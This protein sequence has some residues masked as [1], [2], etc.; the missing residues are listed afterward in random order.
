MTQVYFRAWTLNATQAT[1]HV[2]FLG[3]LRGQQESWE[4][5]LRHWLQRLPC[6]E[7]K[8][9]VGNFLSVYR[10]RPSRDADGHSDDDGADEP[11]VLAPEQLTKALC[12]LLPA[13]SHR[14]G[15]AH[16]DDRAH[17]V[18]EAVQQADALWSTQMLPDVLRRPPPHAY[19]DLSADAVRKAARVHPTK[20]HAM[21]PPEEQVAAVQTTPDKTEEAVQ[22]WLAELTGKDNCNAEQA[23][24]CTKLGVRILQELHDSQLEPGNLCRRCSMGPAY[25]EE[26]GEASDR[27]AWS[28]AAL[29]RT[30]SRHPRAHGARPLRTDRRRMAHR[31]PSA[32]APGRALRGQPRLPARERDLCARKLDSGTP[33]VRDACMRS[34]G[35]SEP[36]H[37]SSARVRAV[38]RGPR[39]PA[40]RR[41]RAG[42]SAVPERFFRRHRHLCHE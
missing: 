32:T 38:R 3:H 20:Q 7:T 23:S 25:R 11:F 30:R 22:T 26:K 28:D 4:D 16:N 42:G 17:R 9:N 6:T 10:V 31:S 37:D 1:D 33:G 15:S 8:R 24:F 12:T 35:G 36:R 5:A 34:V 29:G 27:L 41:T 19:T 2:P 40:A 39:V 13:H 21:A 18:A 14:S